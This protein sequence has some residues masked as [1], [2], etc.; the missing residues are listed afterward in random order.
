[1]SGRARVAGRVLGPEGL[2][3]GA[4]VIAEGRVVALEPGPGD[5]RRLLLPGFLDLHVHGGGGADVMDGPDAVQAVA[6]FH[7]RHGTTG[8]CPTTVTRPLEELERTV[9]GVGALPERADQARLLGVHL[10]GPFLA[11][12]RR[13]AQ[14]PYCLAPD[15]SALGRL[16]AAGP[17]A[18]VTLAPELP[19]A[20]ELIGLCRA[21]GVRAS[22][23][24]SGA[25]CEEGRA[26]FQAGAS[27]VT[28]LYNAMRGLTHRE[29]GL[30]AA[31][32]E[33]EGVFLE[34]ILDLHHV[35]PALF[36]LALRAARGKLV[37]VSDAIRAAGLPPGESEL[38]GQVVR[39]AGGKA[40]LADGTL[41]GS[42]LTLDVALR[43][44]VQAGL[45]VEEASALL[46]LHPAQALGR[47]DLG[48]LA[49]GARADLVE[50]DADDLSL[51]RVW[52]GG[53]EVDLA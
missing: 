51:R 30:A 12:A 25:S 34:L 13:G 15:P 48:R 33:A 21:R 28:H 47:E 32:L 10:E 1:M 3:D 20:L 6:R 27:G 39:V 7:V 50:L 24:H 46:S 43:H 8:L 41:A 22:L 53:V 44:A 4:L 29:P 31:A 16:L 17:V 26:G 42:L 2:F 18:T 52:R 23:G 40:T 49:P 38:G 37:L 11:D 19:G 5:P 45:R 36:R 35:H 14:P 9:R